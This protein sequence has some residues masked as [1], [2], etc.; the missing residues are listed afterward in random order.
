MA[1][2]E[3]AALIRSRNEERGIGRLIDSLR[4]QTIADSL[5]IVVID[6]GSEDRTVTEVR[7]RG[8]EPLQ[9]RSEEFTYGRALNVAAN[10]AG[11]P[12]CVS[13]SAHA[14]PRDNGWAARMVACFEDE[15][16][17]CAFGQRMH[18]DEPRPLQEPLLQDFE[19]ARAHPFWGYAN[20]AGGFRRDLWSRRPFDEELAASE[21]LEW[22][23]Y[24][25]RQGWLVLLDPALDIEHSHRDE[26]PRRT[27]RRIRSEVA[28]VSTFQPVD[29]LPLHR[30]VAEWWSGPHLHRSNLRARLD[31]RRMATLAGKYIGLKHPGG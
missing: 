6:S 18:P 27:F 3:L 21:D 11:A 26:G 23:L 15:R 9:I 17:A 13:I 2:P 22:A 5:E 28:C 8:L 4:T 7:N 19:H 1:Q 20:S 29:P 14:R 12:L 30:A 25:Q 16:V 31:P 10:A 24:W